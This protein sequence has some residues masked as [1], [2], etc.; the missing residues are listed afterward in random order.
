MTTRYVPFA[1]SMGGY[2]RA[3]CAP[4]SSPGSRWRRWLSPAPWRTPQ[5]AGVPV[6]AGLYALLLPVLAYAVFGSAPR[7]VGRA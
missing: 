4:T 5:L 6:S 7:V 1:R 2:S 3:G